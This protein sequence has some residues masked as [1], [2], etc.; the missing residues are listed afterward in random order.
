MVNDSKTYQYETICNYDEITS[1]LHAKENV[2]SVFAL[3]CVSLTEQLLLVV[4]LY[5]KV[6]LNAFYQR[7][8]SLSLYYFCFFYV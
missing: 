7:N 3:F 1:F 8:I 2:H 5:E 6:K 4:L